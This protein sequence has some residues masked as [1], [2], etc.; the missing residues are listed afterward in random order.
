MGQ[1]EVVVTS[2]PLDQF[3]Q[4]MRPV[5]KS[6]AQFGCALPVSPESVPTRRAWSPP[7]QPVRQ[8]ST[9]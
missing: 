6:R 3:E 7:Y 1:E 9:R 5:E 2:A 4:S 8:S